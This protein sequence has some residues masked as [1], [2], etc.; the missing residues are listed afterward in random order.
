MQQR[1][2]AMVISGGGSKGAFAGGVAEYLIEHQKLQYQYFL[3]TSTGSL[4]VSHLALGEIQKVKDLYLNIK[5]EEV[6][7]VNPFTTSL[8]NGYT[9]IGINHFSVL[10]NLAK[11]QST[12]GDSSNL[13]KYLEKNFTFEEFLRL[14]SSFK[15][16]AVTVSNL[17]ENLPEYKR[18][19]ECT[20]KEF[21]DWIWISCNYIP[22]MSLVKVD[23][24]QYADGGFS[25]QIPI[26]KAIELGAEHVD[27]IVLHTESTQINPMPSTNPFSLMS[28]VFDFMI[29]QVGK[30]DILLGKS[31]AKQH[32]VTLDFYFIPN[33]LTTNSLVFNKEQMTLW[34]KQGFEFAKEKAK[35]NISDT[36]G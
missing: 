33:V 3:G 30:K 24:R 35:S 31:M 2:R 11:G 7:S 6:F 36:G 1:Q 23:G 13:R 19:D 32:G 28:T 14:Q 5:Q 15:I 34:W 22:F 9:K 21:L 25:C 20:Y 27:V 16:I 4:L 26:A 8:K 12:F 18:L 10:Q 29:D 17:T